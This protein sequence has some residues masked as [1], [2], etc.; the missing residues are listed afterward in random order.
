MERQPYNSLH[1]CPLLAP[2]VF[3]KEQAR[4]WL[5]RVTYSLPLPLGEWVTGT[6]HVILFGS[7]PLPSTKIITVTFNPSVQTVSPDG[8]MLLLFLLVS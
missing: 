7:P 2:R 4:P 5:T 6:L 8:L 1:R 3:C